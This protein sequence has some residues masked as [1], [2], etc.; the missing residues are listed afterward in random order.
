MTKT[1]CT[2][3]RFVK[4]IFSRACPSLIFIWLFA[5]IALFTVPVLVVASFGP[6]T[7]YTVGSHP[8]SVFVADLNNDGNADMATANYGSGTVSV[9]LND[10][11]GA[12]AT[13]VGYAAGSNPSTV[14]VADLDGDGDADLAVANFTSD[15]VSILLN[16]GDGTFA[17]AVNYAAGD[18]AW[19]VF[20]RNLNGD[21]DLDLVVT[22][23]NA[24][25]VS[26]LLNNG[27]GTFAT[28]VNYAVQSVPASVH[29]IDLDGDGDADLAVANYFGATVSIL[30][31]SGDGTFAA[32]VNYEVGNWSA[33]QWNYP[34]ALYAAD[35]DGDGD[36]DIATAN[37]DNNKVSILLNNGDGTFG[38][39]VEYAVGSHPPSVFAA[40]IDFDGDRDIVTANY[41]GGTVSVLLNNGDGTFV[42]SADYHAGSGP[43]SVFAADMDRD[44]D[45]DLAITSYDADKVF[46]LLSNAYVL[47]PPLPAAPLINM[48]VTTNP[49]SLPDGSGHVT[50][51]YTVTNPGRVTV[52][53]IVLMDKECG[54]AILVSGDLN[55]NTWLETNET[56][57]YTCTVT[58]LE[59]TMNLATVRG[60]GNGLEATDASI[61]EVSVGDAVPPP[62]IHLTKVPEPLSL[63]SEGG[64]VTYVYAVTNSGTQPLRNVS[65]TEEACQD[66]KY[67]EGDMDEDSLLELG[68]KWVYKCTTTV[69]KTT[70]GVAVVSGDANGR[71][72]V[73]PA[74][75]IV[76]IANSPVPNTTGPY[77]VEK[78]LQTSPS[79][80]FDKG[81]A[82]PAGVSSGAC[83]SGTLLKLADDGNSRTLIDA[84]VY[85]CGE[86]TQRHVFPNE[87][88]F[89][90]W[91]PDVSEIVP[92]SAAQ[93]AAISIG[94][95]VTFRPGTRLIKVPSHPKVYAVAK[96]GVLRWVTSEEVARTLYGPDW[97][98]FVT[99]MSEILFANYI[100]GAPISLSD[101]VPGVLPIPTPT[102]DS[103]SG[104][105]SA[106]T[107][108]VAFT[109]YLSLGSVDT[110]V[111]PLQI[112]LQ[113]LNF[114]PSD[115]APTGYFGPVTAAA[116]KKFQSA[117]NVEPV[118]YV[119]PATRDMLNRYLRER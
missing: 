73:D 24:A 92:V 79:I 7:S 76:T 83:K 86:D 90:S 30:L 57:V 105:S 58:F 89:R 49:P 9:L 104:R 119:G 80:N 55:E 99:D 38:P 88:T 43:W 40:D 20:S 6:A 44:S 98:H 17:A 33:S 18:G 87:A 118:G 48:K 107:N 5:L 26:V 75:A 101:A 96:N 25:T 4:R 100:V 68:E 66:V 2:D 27:D 65:V 61:V 29:A 16:N 93:L 8:R 77:S 45:I 42:T 67:V 82:L 114:F 106:C 117:H 14:F 74:I 108:S 69:L 95:N 111:R 39:S 112:L 35:L 78:V 71:R 51:T 21:D 28:A 54:D 31:N 13:A 109:R 12:F 102:I 56:W 53:D 11:S 47:P 63:P 1:L 62:L 60:L 41:F 81:L 103:S 50:F 110:D 10:G 91:Y 36:A 59:T 70:I 34:I 15:N 116:V 113:C 72:A 19:S 46:I 97:S 85:Y 37:Y 3:T 84:A 64:L 52:T 32:A 23:S 94:G 115:I 22:N